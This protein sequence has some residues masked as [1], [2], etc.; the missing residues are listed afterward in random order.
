MKICTCRQNSRPFLA[1]YIPALLLGVSA[2]VCRRARVDELGMIIN[3]METHNRLMI[4][5]HGTHY[6][7]QQRNSNQ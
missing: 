2:G 1:K 5:V 7:I 6:T 4:A 3:E